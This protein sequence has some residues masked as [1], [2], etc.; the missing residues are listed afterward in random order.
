MTVHERMTREGLTMEAAIAELAAECKW[1][2][3]ALT[4]SGRMLGKE[5][6]R[7][8]KAEAERDRLREELPEMKAMEALLHRRRRTLD[9]GPTANAGLLNELDAVLGTAGGEETPGGDTG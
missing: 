4:E 7:G 8:V 2:Q 5:V 1:L 3:A 9:P 6:A